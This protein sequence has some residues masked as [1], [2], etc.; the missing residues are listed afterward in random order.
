MKTTKQKLILKVELTGQDI[1]NIIRDHVVRVN[2]RKPNMEKLLKKAG[3]QYITKIEFKD[4]GTGNIYDMGAV[5]EV[6]TVEEKKT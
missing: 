6:L 2:S 5:V 3:S 4:M 1:F